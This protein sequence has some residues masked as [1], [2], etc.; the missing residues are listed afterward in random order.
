[1]K[2]TCKNCMCDIVCPHIDDAD[3]NRCQFYKDKE[4]LVEVVRCKDCKWMVEE[5]YCVT[6]VKGAGYKKPKPDDF[7]SY[8]ERKD[9]AEND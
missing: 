9:G 6:N 8:G 5:G 2:L 4:R 1:M 3:A 7:C